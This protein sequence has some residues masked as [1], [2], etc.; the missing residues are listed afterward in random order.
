MTFQG[1]YPAMITPF[2]RGALDEEALRR[3]A[4]G[5]IRGGSAGLVAC[6]STGE[7][8]TLT[9]AEYKRVIVAAKEV[10]RGRVPVIAGVGTNATWKAVETARAAAARGADALLAL[11]PYYNK[12]TQEGLFL[13]FRE[14][15]RAVRVPVIVYNIPGRTAVNVLPATVLKIAAACPNVVAVKEASGSLDQVSE[16]V[17]GAKRGFSVLSGDDSLTVPMMSVGAKGVISVVANIV[18]RETARMCAAMLKGRPAE[19]ERLHRKLFPLIKA[20]FIETN[21]IPVKAAA[22]LLGLCSPEL[23]LPLTP[24]AAANRPKLAAAMKA[25]GLR[26]R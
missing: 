7:A 21:P 2:R 12:P 9:P 5:L 10:A 8:A 3:L 22:G 24:L 13:H 11:A 1:S 15:A 6:G 25:A 4:D 20:L 26:L 17:G 14:L 19:A 23:R 18:P 16:I